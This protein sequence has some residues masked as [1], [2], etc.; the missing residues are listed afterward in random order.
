LLP[1]LIPLA[2]AVQAPGAAHVL[3][4]H[5][6]AARTGV[7][8][9]EQ[10]LTPASVN[11]RTFGKLWTLY[12]DGQVVA[13]PL[14]LSGLAVETS[15][16][17]DIPRVQGTFNAILIATMHNTVYLYDADRERPGPEGRTV[18]LWAT[19]LGKPRP[20]GPDIDMWA[21]NDPEWG[22][23]GTPV[24]DTTRSIVYLVAWHDDGGGGE[25]YR[26]RLHALRLKDGTH[27][28]PPVVLEAPGLNSV[29]QK[30]RTGLLLTGAP[31]RSAGAVVACCSRAP[32]P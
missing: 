4:S 26:Y 31:V 27:L 20:G 32:R 8:P 12:A 21:A 29:K 10:V 25:N 1:A 16:N 23:L 13:Q 7:N 2:L 19:W 3:T 14:Y 15:G 6:T 28:S 11:A 22:I 18:P 9:A 5:N 24:I 30:Q 17:P